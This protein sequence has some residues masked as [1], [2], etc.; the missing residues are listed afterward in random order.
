MSKE[1]FLPSES[2]WKIMEQLW[3]SDRA[4]TTLEIQKRIEEE[5]AMTLR[6]V[7]VLTNRLLKKGLVGFEVDKK[8]ARVYHYHAL[9]SREECVKEKSKSFVDNYF[10]GSQT[11][12]CAALLQTG[13]LTDEQIKELEEILE[14]SKE[15][16]GDKL[17]RD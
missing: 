13:T 3:N 1:E 6:T 15:K 14:Q 4:L 10:A 12:A 8:D 17:C 7:R 2:E 16:G 5:S 11:S 9:K